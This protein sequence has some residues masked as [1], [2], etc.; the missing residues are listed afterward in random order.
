MNGNAV[1]ITNNRITVTK[2]VKVTA[3]SYGDD[4]YVSKSVEQTI[5]CLAQGLY[6]TARS[7][8]TVSH[9]LAN[10]MT[11]FTLSG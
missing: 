7:I 1:Q 6:G 5:S 8:P 4:E 11:P 3:T 2:D 9:D 10:D